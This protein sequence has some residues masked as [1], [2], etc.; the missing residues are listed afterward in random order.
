MALVDDEALG[1]VVISEVNDVVSE[2]LKSCGL[3]YR[4][5]LPEGRTGEAFVEQTLIQLSF[6]KSGGWKLKTD[7][8]D[9]S[10]WLP[11]Q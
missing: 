7:W 9:W 3:K 8:F 2:F 5:P 10:R 4:A 6:D 1:V 11:K